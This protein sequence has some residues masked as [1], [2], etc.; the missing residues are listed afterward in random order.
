MRNQ[1]PRSVRPT[2]WAPALPVAPGCPTC[3]HALLQARLACWA[4]YEGSRVFYTIASIPEAPQR[5]C[6]C[7]E[8]K[9]TMYSQDDSPSS[10]PRLACEVSWLPPKTLKSSNQYIIPQNTISLATGAKL[11]PPVGKLKI[12]HAQATATDSRL[13]LPPALS[14][15]FRRHTGPLHPIHH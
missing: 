3:S 9:M 8:R 13:Q 11:F 7:T 10:E 5:Q 14:P 6:V 4:P 12:T 15:G 1:G 2:L